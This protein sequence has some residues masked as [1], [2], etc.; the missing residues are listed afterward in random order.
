MQVFMIVLLIIVLI[1]GAYGYSI[2]R[3]NAK[4]RAKERRRNQFNDRV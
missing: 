2:Y 3:T 1:V 4:Q